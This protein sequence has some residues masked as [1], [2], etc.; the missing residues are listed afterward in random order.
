VNDPLLLLSDN[1]IKTQVFKKDLID[2][3]FKIDLIQETQL[4]QAQN[5]HLVLI[6]IHHHFEFAKTCLKPLQQF[7]HLLIFDSKKHLRMLITS[8]IHFIF[9]VLLN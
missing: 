1:M 7:P 4:E 6:D 2:A 8:K 9:S 3:G 5:Y